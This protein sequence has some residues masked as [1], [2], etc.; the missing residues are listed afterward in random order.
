MKT[1]RDWLPSLTGSTRE[2]WRLN[3]RLWFGEPYGTDVLSIKLDAGWPGHGYRPLD[4][5]FTFGGED[6]DFELDV[7]LWWFSMYLSLCGVFSWDTRRAVHAWT[8]R[9][10]DAINAEAGHKKVWAYALDPFAGRSTGVSIHHRHLWFEFW[11]GDAGTTFADTPTIKHSG[12]AGLRW[13]QRWSIQRGVLPWNA[14]GGWQWNIDLEWLMLLGDTTYEEKVLD[15]V[16]SWVAMPEGDYPAT[17]DVTQ[18]RWVRRGPIGWLFGL[19]RR[20]VYRTK[21]DIPGGIPHPGKGEN[22]WDLGDDGLWG[23]SSAVQ[24]EP[25]TAHYALQQVA[26]SVLET[27]QKRGGLRWVP[28]DGWPDHLIRDRRTG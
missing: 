9:R 4:L 19:G 28:N 25:P 17:V 23:T 13:W 5:K 16:V 18:V 7:S 21:I 14:E 22:S 12:R 11:R 2:A 8:E 6:R 26:I 3:R 27:R 20:W 1:I 24:D 10:V 15:S